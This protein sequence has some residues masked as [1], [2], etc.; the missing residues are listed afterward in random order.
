MEY[1][2][3]AYPFTIKQMIETAAKR[4]KEQQQK[5][6]RRDKEI[7]AKFA[8]LAQWKQDLLDKV[9]KKTAEANAAKVCSLIIYLTLFV[10]VW[11]QIS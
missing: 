9:A 3:V 5:I 7:A 4:R 2:S 8:K 11:L 6:E 10:C 1:E